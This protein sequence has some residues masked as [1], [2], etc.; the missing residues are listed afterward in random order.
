M[1]VFG[2]NF[3]PCQ[4]IWDNDQR[5]FWALGSSVHSRCLHFIVPYFIALNMHFPDSMFSQI[6]E[7]TLIIIRYLTDDTGRIDLDRFS[8]IEALSDLFYAILT[9][10][11]D[12]IY[13]SSINSFGNR[14][15]LPWQPSKVRMVMDQFKALLQVTT[16]AHFVLWQ[17]WTI[18]ASIICAS[19]WT[20]Q[21]L[22]CITFSALQAYLQTQDQ[23]DEVLHRCQDCISLCPSSS[24]G[25]TPWQ[26]ELG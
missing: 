3:A 5:F 19:F 4:S 6:V 21:L 14:L 8:Q 26:H 20:K 9:T 16:M 12:C 22:A 17:P 1:A 25:S 7:F 10:C 13:L 2:R 11:G 24:Q 15:P 23:S 18:P